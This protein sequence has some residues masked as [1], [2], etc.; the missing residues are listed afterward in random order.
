MRP[1]Y[2]VWTHDQ[3]LNIMYLNYIKLSHM[4]GT[5]QLEIIFIFW[6]WMQFFKIEVFYTLCGQF[7]LSLLPTNQPT[8]ES[9]KWFLKNDLCVCW[10]DC[11]ENILSII[12]PKLIKIKTTNF[13]H[14]IRLMHKKCLLVLKKIERPEVGKN[15]PEMNVSKTA[16]TIFFKLDK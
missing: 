3:D 15:R 14:N 6:I 16:Q 4:I 2:R 13:I 10:C 5:I 9:K 11:A 12:S 7:A 8:P 1:T